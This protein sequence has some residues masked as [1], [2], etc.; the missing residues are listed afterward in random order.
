VVLADSSIAVNTENESPI[1]SDSYNFYPYWILYSKETGALSYGYGIHPAQNTLGSTVLI[2]KPSI[3]AYSFGNP[4]EKPVYFK[5]I[6][7]FAPQDPALATQYADVIARDSFKTTAMTQ[8]EITYAWN[9]AWKCETPN[10]ATL[11]FKAKA[12]HSI[13]V[14]LGNPTDGAIYEIIYGDYDNTETVILKNKKVVARSRD[15]DTLIP[16]A[17]NT[18]SYWINFYKGHIALGTGN[19]VYKNQVLEWFDE[20]AAKTI[21]HFSCSSRA[22][23]SLFSDITAVPGI[24]L[25]LH[26]T[27]SAYAERGVFTWPAYWTLV[28]PEKGCI[29]GEVKTTDAA[30]IGLGKPGKALYSISLGA[31]CALL[32]DGHVQLSS[33]KKFSR[34]NEYTTFWVVFDKGYI[35]CGTGNKPSPESLI[36]ESQ[37]FA[38]VDII[39]N[40]SL[41]S[42]TG[43]A[44]Y[45]ALQSI[46]VDTIKYSYNTSWVANSQRKT[47]SFTDTWKLPVADQG[48]VLCDIRGDGPYYIGFA[49]AFVKQ[50]DPDLEIVIGA[51]NNTCMQIR[52][53]G[54]VVAETKD[55]RGIISSSEFPSSYW[56]SYNKGVVMV[57]IDKTPGTNTLVS[58]TDSSPSPLTLVSFS[59]DKTTVTYNH[60]QFAEPAT[61]QS[62]SELVI[63]AG[64]SAYT[65]KQPWQ[66][67]KPNFGSI[68][69]KAK[70]KKDICIGFSAGMNNVARYEV[71]IG[72]ENNSATI[73]KCNNAIV[74]RMNTPEAQIRNGFI[75]QDYWIALD[76]GS[77][78]VGTGTVP[79]NNLTLFWH[80]STAQQQNPA[81]SHVGF[82]SGSE[83]VTLQTITPKPG[84]PLLPNKYY[85]SSQQKGAYTW[86]HNWRIQPNQTITLN[87]TTPQ[88]G[89]YIGFNQ[90][91]AGAPRYSILLGGWKN[92]KSALFKD[93]VL[94]E[95]F[96]VTL[97]PIGSQSLWIMYRPESITIGSGEPHTKELYTWKNPTPD[98]NIQFFA[99]SSDF[100]PVLCDAI[101]VIP[102][103]AI[104]IPKKAPD[105]PIVE[106]SP[107]PAEQPETTITPDIRTAGSA[108]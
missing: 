93:G 47:Y 96:D 7:A 36:L 101:G 62:P 29:L 22:E 91:S 38:T 61:Q 75:P 85:T 73:I 26:Q 57:G 89:L 67:S 34:D 18:Y 65:Y 86:N 39:Q 69:F 44:S 13:A 55:P 8:K 95:Q 68:T 16:N 50:A 64:T 51:Q 77:L 41:S 24:K 35:A 15:L 28:K 20:E 99:L 19:E 59:S 72:A 74:A 58:W 3:T 60:I 70:A 53:K 42:S 23:G 107:V 33:Q 87:A 63:A 100:G 9:N 32:K 10:T 1:I 81:I 94:V 78:A 90:L 45:R 76:N 17:A 30:L 54:V 12:P 88:G 56:I 80:D 108:G 2:S 83:M 40:F 105:T 84:I 106:L 98:S 92:T 27:Y 48:T 5:N 37:N 11:S 4:T 25:P 31:T 46:P 103:Q 43:Q 6:G 49:N 97:K 102:A 66:L 21:S 82:A 71:I 14:A 52:K 104:Q 79:G